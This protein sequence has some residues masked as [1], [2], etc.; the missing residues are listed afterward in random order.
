MYDGYNY[1]F[2]KG[3]SATTVSAPQT[4]M[5]QGQSIVIT[6]T[7]LDQ[8]PA[9]TDTPCVSKESMRTQMEYLHMQKPIDGLWHNETIAGVSVSLDTVDPNGNYIHIGDTVTDG[10]SGTFGYTWEP[11]IAGQYTVTA[12]FMGDESYGSSFATTYVGIS[13]APAESPTPTAISFESINNTTITAI[14]G[15]TIAIIIAI[16]IA[17]LLTLRKRP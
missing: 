6:G 15:A 8:S 4:V 13:E 3:K 7:V 1:Y 11:E 14:I 9:Q 5:T 10:Y 12:T 2:G 17:M 16:A